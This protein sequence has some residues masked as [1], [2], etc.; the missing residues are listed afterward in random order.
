MLL[1]RV[2]QIVVSAKRLRLANELAK[3]AEAFAT[4]ANQLEAPINRLIQLRKLVRE[5][6]EFG[7]NVVFDVAVAQGVARRAGEILQA[8]SADPKSL[9]EGDESF[10]QEFIPGVNSVNQQLKVALE[11]GWHQRVDKE[12]E[13]LPEDILAALETV[14]AYRHQIQ[15]IRRCDGEAKLLRSV[16]P[17]MGE[18]SDK[19]ILLERAIRTKEMAWNSL[20]GSQLSDEVVDF[21]RQAGAQGFPL[22][23][24][25]PTVTQWLS[26][27]GLLGCFRIRAI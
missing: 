7:I 20:K 2:A 18:V 3:E 22:E 12:F 9:T 26:E 27:C 17:G 4:R 5:F 10:R 19:L 23:N 25:T 11:V 8:F 1:D 21:L 16:L 14:S 15:T 6:S 13:E 24:L